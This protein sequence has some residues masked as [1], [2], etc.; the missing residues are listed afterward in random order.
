MTDWIGSDGAYFLNKR[1]DTCINS[2]GGAWSGWQ[3]YKPHNYYTSYPSLA[4]GFRLWF[5]LDN[6]SNLIRERLS[7]C[8]KHNKDIVSE[9]SINFN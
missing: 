3:A 5:S 7:F 4:P 1:S 8:L 2:N 9:V 6:R